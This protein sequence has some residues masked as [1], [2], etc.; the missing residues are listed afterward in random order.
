MNLVST[1]SLLLSMKSGHGLKHRTPTFINSTES[2]HV[3]DTKPGTTGSKSVGNRHVRDKHN[4]TL[5]AVY[6]CSI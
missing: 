4:K 5:R 6:F 3:M 1:S 2:G